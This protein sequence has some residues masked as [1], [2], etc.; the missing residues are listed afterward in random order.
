M[1]IAKEIAKSLS[2][3]HRMGPSMDHPYKAVWMVQNTPQSILDHPY[4]RAD[5][6]SSV[7]VIISPVPRRGYGGRRWWI[8]IIAS[9][10]IRGGE[11]PTIENMRSETRAG[12]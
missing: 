10:Y 1:E 9:Y 2:V 3:S 11:G 4:K 8:R 12:Q 6:G 5:I 7:L